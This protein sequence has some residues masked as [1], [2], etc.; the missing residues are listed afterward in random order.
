MISYTGTVEENEKDGDR[1]I[2]GERTERERND[3]LN[4]KTKKHIGEKQ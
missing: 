2:E 4:R 3:R 1:Q